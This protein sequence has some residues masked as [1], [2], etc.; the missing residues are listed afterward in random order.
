MSGPCVD[1]GIPDYARSSYVACAIKS[2]LSESNT[3]WQLTVFEE[4]GPTEPVKRAISHISLTNAF[5]TSRLVAALAWLG[6][7][8]AW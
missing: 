5:G 7:S 1:I 3:N 4:L 6:T 8:R 2:V